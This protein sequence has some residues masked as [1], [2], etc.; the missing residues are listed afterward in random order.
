ML[1]NY[2]ADKNC[3]DRWGN[4]PLQEASNNKHATV[5]SLLTQWKAELGLDSAAFALCAAAGVGDMQQV[6]RFIENGI[7]PNLG[8]YD[9]RTALHVASAAG[10][11]KV[12]EYLLSQK[13]N[14]NPADRW[15]GTPLQDALLNGN[16]LVAALLKAKGGL[17]PEDVGV[18]E[19]C[20]ATSKGDVRKMR[21]M[22]D[23]G[24][25]TDIGDYDY[26]YPREWLR[27]RGE[28]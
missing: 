24:I 26:R 14:P 3:K 12:V 22:H 17:M 4:T 18:E 25:P 15:K 1:L 2:G 16:A 20:T 19:M 6:R 10:H 23:Y 9:L 28:R 11:D 21:L 8:D 7:D 27:R 13:A 5:I